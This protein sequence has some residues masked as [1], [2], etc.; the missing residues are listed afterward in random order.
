M[1]EKS[2]FIY[3][4]LH[5]RVC[6]QCIYVDTQIHESE[7]FP[8]RQRTKYFSNFESVQCDAL[9]CSILN[10]NVFSLSSQSG[11]LRKTLDTFYI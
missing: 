2:S 5:L 7:L 1:S 3:I 10:Q 6:V 11:K 9:Q 4:I 8:C